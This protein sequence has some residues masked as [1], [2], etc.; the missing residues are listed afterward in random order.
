MSNWRTQRSAS[1][2]ARTSDPSISSQDSITEPLRSSK[3]VNSK[4]V[5]HLGDNTIESKRILIIFP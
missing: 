4:E 2:E 5:K 1:D 3:F